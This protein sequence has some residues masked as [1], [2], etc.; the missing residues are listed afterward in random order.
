V[1]D[2]GAPAV[3]RL[4]WDSEFFGVEIGRLDR[5]GSD[6]EI[7]EA[8]RAADASGIDCSYLLLAGTDSAGLAIAQGRGFRVVDVR[9]VLE[10]PL[11]AAMAERDGGT[12]PAETG[13]RDWVLDLARRRF[14]HSR[15]VADPSFGPD[16]G[17]ELFARWAQRGFDDADRGVIV[18]DDAA[19]FVVTGRSGNTGSI[20]LIT[21]AEHAPKGAGGRL[22]DGA[23]RAFVSAGCDAVDVVTQATNVPALRLYERCGYRVTR[24]S[25]WL[26]RW[27]PDRNDRSPRG[28]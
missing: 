28:R 2:A 8:L 27:R 21:A 4:E 19:G 17:A 9:V 22:L 18:L 24:S 11:D 20:E 6:A 16:A 3:D 1:N 15:F 5:T 23:H 12:R 26:H 14:D 25:Y 7:G 10:R 13:D